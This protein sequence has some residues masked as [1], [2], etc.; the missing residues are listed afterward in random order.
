[1]DYLESG[2]EV[3]KQVVCIMDEW[4]HEDYLAIGH[5][6]SYPLKDQILTVRDILPPDEREPRFG[7]RFHEIRNSLITFDHITDEPAFVSCYFRP[8]RD[9]S[10]ECFTKILVDLPKEVE[11]V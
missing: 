1:V 6:I 5:K 4:N 7:L 8:V 2:I 10:I 11:T 9:T 3:G